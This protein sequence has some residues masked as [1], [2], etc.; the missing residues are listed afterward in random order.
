MGLG[1]AA[2]AIADIR[3]GQ[4]LAVPAAANLVA[5]DPILQTQTQG[6]GRRWVCAQVVGEVE[7]EVWARLLHGWVRGGR[8]G[9]RAA[10]RAG[11]RRATPRCAGGSDG[12]RCRVCPGG[13]RSGP[14]PLGLA[15]R[16]LNCGRRAS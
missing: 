2:V 12:S 15:I 8:V 10:G 5:S 1:V 7:V 11:T 4:D 16:A 6:N 13:A 3:I 14:R 9:C